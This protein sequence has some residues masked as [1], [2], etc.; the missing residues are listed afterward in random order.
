MT[1]KIL[2]V[3]MALL[4]A[5]VF[6]GIVKQNYQSKIAPIVTFVVILGASSILSADPRF[7][8]T[9]SATCAVIDDDI[10][11]TCA[12]PLTGGV[13]ERLIIFNKDD[14]VGYT[15]AAGGR[16]VEA[17]NLVAL[18]TG[19]TWQGKQSSL[20]PRVA[21]IVKPFAKP[22]DHIIDALLFDITDATKEQLEL[23]NQGRFVAVVENNYRN[24]AVGDTAFEIYGMEAGLELVKLERNPNDVD[25]VGAWVL[26]LQSSEKGKEGKLPVTFFKTDY[27][28]SLALL[29]GYL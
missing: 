6:A 13:N 29:N 22:F 15:F 21:Q 11:V 7:K 24:G 18:K 10:D 12:N 25:N 1:K 20:S 23:A 5:T 8:G 19:F 16:I 2:T 9:L 28:A 17:I 26:T 27:A 4:F 14:I 3:I